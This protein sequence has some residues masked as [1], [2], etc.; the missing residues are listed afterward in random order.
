M[1]ASEVHD[2]LAQGLTYMRM[3][4]SLLRD[5]IRRRRRAARAQVLERRRR[6]ARQLAAPAA[7]ADHL[8]P[9]P[10]G[11]AGTAACARAKPAS[12]SSI[13]P[14]SRSSSSTGCRTCALPPDRE[15][16]VFHIVQEALAN[17][18]RHAH[19]RRAQLVIGRARR[20]G[21][22]IV[23]EDDGVGMAAYARGRR[24]RRCRALRHC[25]HARARAPPRRRARLDQG[26]A[27][28]G[29]RVRLNFPATDRTEREP[30][31]S[32]PIKRRPDRRSRP[33]PPRPVRAARSACGHQGPR[34][35]GQAPT[36]RCACCAT[37]ART[38]RSWTCGWCRS[39]AHQLLT[40]MRA[41]GIDT[42]VVVLTMS[43]SPEDLAARSAP[44]CAATC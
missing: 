30:T 1:M 37:S 35:H 11:S 25:H 40:R 2:S 21:Y 17:V 19:A 7:R 4:M 32:D 36:R 16:E 8:F 24:P 9:Q 15:I 13:G 31:M 5:A 3:R 18:C 28:G 34:E 14:A 22:A 41:E 42:P 26:A 29:T 39:T 12:A 38:S 33:V 10:D 23:V 27:T 43:D 20:A 6:H 44:A